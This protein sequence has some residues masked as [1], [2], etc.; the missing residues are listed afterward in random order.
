MQLRIGTTLICGCAA[1]HI[2]SCAAEDSPSAEGETKITAL[3]AANGEKR[4]LAE[5]FNNDGRA[6]LAVAESDANAVAIFLGDG[7]GGFSAPRRFD[8]GPMP[9]WLTVLD[10][11]KDGAL[12]LAVANHEAG[13]LTVLH[14]DGEGGFTPAPGSPFPVAASPHAHMIEAADMDGDRRTDLV[15]DSRDEHGAYVLRG[16]A[17]G[18][19]DAPG[20][21]INLGAPYLGF[22]LGDIDSDGKTDIVL[23]DRGAVTVSLN[24]TKDVFDFEKTAHLPMPGVFSLDLIDLDADGQLDI[25]AASENG[26]ALIFGGDGAG[27]FA[28]RQNIPIAAGAKSIAVGDSNGDGIGDAL[29]ASWSGDMALVIGGANVTVKRLPQNGIEAPWGIALADF[30]SDGR[31]EIA[32]ADA[33]SERIVVYKLTQ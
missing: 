26:D 18:G 22:V 21:P 15:I 17:D 3:N 28:K 6:D 7:D 4:L 9:T 25:I 8:A 29:I 33:I 32:V 13:G 20:T 31:D 19:F 16:L 11:N 1:L 5:D 10:A 12:D 14:G 23:P 2:V 27:N 24:R 30:D